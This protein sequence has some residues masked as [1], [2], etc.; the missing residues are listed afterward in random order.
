[1]KAHKGKQTNN[2]G[3]KRLRNKTDIK[4]G[5]EVPSI[6]LNLQTEASQYLVQQGQAKEG[7]GGKA[8]KKFKRLERDLKYR[9]RAPNRDETTSLDSCT[10][11]GSL[12]TPQ[13]T[14]KSPKK[15]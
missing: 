7:G 4:K 15:P 9:K 5:Q 11:R 2:I 14:L 1:M 6:N 3:M 8:T 12:K 13:A 10:C